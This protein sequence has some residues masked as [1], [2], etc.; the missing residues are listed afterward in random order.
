M[1]FIIC[2]CLF[3]LFTFVFRKEPAAFM[4]L[5][6]VLIVVTLMGLVFAAIAI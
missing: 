3:A 2:Y 4:V 1:A 6:P 5:F